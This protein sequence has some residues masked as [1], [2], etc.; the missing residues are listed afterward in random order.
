MSNHR[1]SSDQTEAQLSA[2]WMQEIA[3]P[4]GNRFPDLERPTTPESPPV[5]GIVD[6]TPVRA[7]LITAFD[8][9]TGE[10]VKD[11]DVLRMR[12]HFRESEE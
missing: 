12:C 4:S 10:R 3:N 6:R 7:D 1:R 5:P 2:A 9:P 8:H 11:S